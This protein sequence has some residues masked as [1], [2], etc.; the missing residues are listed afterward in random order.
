MGGVCDYQIQSPRIC[1][2]LPRRHSSSPGKDV[3][4]IPVRH[5][6]LFRNDLPFFNFKFPPKDRGKQPLQ[7]PQEDKGLEIRCHCVPQKPHEQAE[8]SAHPAPLAP[9]VLTRLQGLGRAHCVHSHGQAS[10]LPRGQDP[11]DARSNSHSVGHHDVFMEPFN[12]L[13]P[14]SLQ[15]L[16]AALPRLSW[17]SPKTLPHQ[18]CPSFYTA[19]LLEMK[20]SLGAQQNK[21]QL[22]A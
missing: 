20:P 18:I 15:F 3:S 9:T 6:S 13:S 16:S 22:P 21:T 19:S 17:P 5:H 12:A 10:H 14:A 1:R 2:T 4:R 7:C 11:T 8:H